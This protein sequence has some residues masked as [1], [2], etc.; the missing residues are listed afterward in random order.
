MIPNT[1]AERRHNWSHGFKQL[2]RRLGNVKDHMDTW[3]ARTVSAIGG[4]RIVREGPR[5]QSRA[6]QG[7]SSTQSIFCLFHS[8]LKA[9][10]S[11]WNLSI[12]SLQN[13]MPSSHLQNYLNYLI[14]K[15]WGFAIKCAFYLG[16]SGDNML[17]VILY[18]YYLCF[19]MYCIF[20]DFRS[21]YFG[22]TIFWILCT[23]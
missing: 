23:F 15:L 17:L 3:G 11:F 20:N 6:E 14:W 5:E 9:R 19:I 18:I 10:Y 21:E 13:P 16:S 22:S 2:Q 1:S 4:F 7:M 12:Q 8:F